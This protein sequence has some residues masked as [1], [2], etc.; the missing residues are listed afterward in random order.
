MAFALVNVG[1]GYAISS[2]EIVYLIRHS[3]RA[4]H[5][6]LITAP[7]NSLVFDADASVLNSLVLMLGSRCVNTYMKPILLSHCSAHTDIA[8]RHANLRQSA[9]NGWRRDA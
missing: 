6:I 7:W 2:Q 5:I 9:W 1:T 4:T 8:M 3:L